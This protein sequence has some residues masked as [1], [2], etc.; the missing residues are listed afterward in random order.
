MSTD[1]EAI[2]SG[3]NMARFDSFITPCEDA[4]F[5]FDVRKAPLRNKVFQ[6]FPKWVPDL[7]STSAFIQID[8]N[9]EIPSYEAREENF[10]LTLFFKRGPKNVFLGV[11]GWTI[12]IS[13]P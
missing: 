1:Q 9:I 2:Q 7:S 3:S 12:D 5:Q 10:S 4:I 6:P 13:D 8:C 11:D